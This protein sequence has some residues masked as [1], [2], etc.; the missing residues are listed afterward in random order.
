[1]SII[2]TRR[3]T[4]N[5]PKCRTSHFG[6]W[7][8]PYYSNPRMF[9]LEFLS[10]EQGTGG[11]PQE[12]SSTK[13][14]KSLLAHHRTFPSQAH[15]ALWEW[16]FTGPISIIYVACVCFALCFMGVVGLCLSYNYMR[17]HAHT[18]LTHN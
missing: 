7:G 18:T 15:K 2:N 12:K 5:N 3:L 13:K 14:S 4:T 6:C 11:A 1:M 9:Y 10:F 16:V 8:K 17:R